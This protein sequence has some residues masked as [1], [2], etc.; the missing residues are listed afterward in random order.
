MARPVARDLQSRAIVLIGFVIRIE[1]AGRTRCVPTVVVGGSAV[2]A[3]QKSDGNRNLK[4][5]T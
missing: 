5:E 1:T 3:L 2:V 4:S